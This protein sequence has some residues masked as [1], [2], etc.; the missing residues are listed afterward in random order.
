MVL[1]KK[2]EQRKLTSELTVDF[3]RRYW[4]RL[5]VLA[6]R[7]R[8]LL[9]P[10]LKDAPAEEKQD[11]FFNL[12]DFR[13]TL[14][15]FYEEMS[16]WI[17]GTDPTLESKTVSL[18]DALYEATLPILNR[19]ESSRILSEERLRDGDRL[20]FFKVVDALRGSDDGLKSAYAKFEKWLTDSKNVETTSRQFSEYS[21]NLK[22]V[23]K[24]VFP[25][26]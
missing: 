9:T 7:L 20:S 10:M 16:G 21:D 3:V 26:Y 24:S 23:I 19:Y 15:R 4:A 13:R 1:S 12:L 11:A 17:P 22:K 14:S 8:R 6:M 18:Q 25:L 5:D 2:W